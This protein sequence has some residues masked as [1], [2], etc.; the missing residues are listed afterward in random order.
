[1]EVFR[2]LNKRTADYMGEIASRAD[3]V[4]EV[5]F[6]FYK[7]KMDELGK[8]NP[9]FLRDLRKYP[10]VINYIRESHKMADAEAFAYFKR[11]VE[12]G[13][14]RSDINFE[15][16]NKATLMQLE[17]LIYSDLTESYPLDE[18]YREITILHMRGI[19]TEKGLKMVDDFLYPVKENL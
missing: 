5:I 6:A 19:I 4:L 8:T 12:Q 13:I 2:L 10:K 14:F 1:M 3:N 17:M 16:I 18:I 15:I 9:A 11:G 7:L